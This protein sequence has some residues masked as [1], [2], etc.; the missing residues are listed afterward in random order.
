MA[1]LAAC[2]AQINTWVICTDPAPGNQTQNELIE[3]GL[4]ITNIK[5]DPRVSPAGPAGAVV[6]GE[7]MGAARGRLRFAWRHCLVRCC[8]WERNQAW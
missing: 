6:L 8:P 1:L 2:I 3:C 5:T 7:H 4:L